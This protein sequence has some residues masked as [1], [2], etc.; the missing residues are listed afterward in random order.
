M[1]VLLT[2]NSWGFIGRNQYQNGNELGHPTGAIITR[3]TVAREDALMLDVLANM[4][5]KKGTSIM[6]QINS[7][8]IR[9]LDLGDRLSDY[10]YSAANSLTC[11][12]LRQVVS[13]L[14]AFI[15]NGY[16]ARTAYNQWGGSVGKRRGKDHLRTQRLGDYRVGRTD[17]YVEPNL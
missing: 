4:A 8:T 11:E 15:A 2:E 12:D 17:F 10:R 9:G 14:N 5:S 1:N 3:D 16:H 6:D 7:G 13:A